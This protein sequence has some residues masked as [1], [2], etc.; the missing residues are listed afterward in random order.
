MAVTTK[1]KK[2]DLKV[3]RFYFSDEIV[4]ESQNSFKR[5]RFPGEADRFSYACEVAQSFDDVLW[6][7]VVP[8]KSGKV[9]LA[10]FVAKESRLTEERFIDTFNNTYGNPR[11]R[12]FRLRKIPKKK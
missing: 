5:R 9:K 3:F 6:V 2:S 7:D 10:V 4:R 11:D 8:C 12:K 1:T